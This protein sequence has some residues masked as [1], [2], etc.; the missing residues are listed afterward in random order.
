MSNAV[1]YGSSYTYDGTSNRM[2][3]RTNGLTTTYSYNP[4][5]QLLT[6]TPA[7]STTTTYSYDARGNRISA[8]N[9]ADTT[10]Y[11]YDALDRLISVSLPTG[12]TAGYRYGA[13][14]RRVPYRLFPKVW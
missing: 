12:M 4:L 10:T 1:L 7:L 11:S 3:Q 2:S 6:V 5:D 14:G 8:T 9:G 13:D